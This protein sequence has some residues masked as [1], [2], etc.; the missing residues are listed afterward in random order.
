NYKCA[1]LES[2]IG[3]IGNNRK[4]DLIIAIELVEH[5]SNPEKFI[6]NCFS[7]LKPNGRVLI[8]TPNK[9]YYRKG[10]IWISDLP[11]VH[12]F[13][14][15]PKTFNYIAEENGL[16][17]KYFDLA[18]HILKHDKINLLINYLRSR[19]KIRIRPHVF[20]ASGELNLENHNSLNQP[21]LLKKLVRFILVDI[22][23]IRI[24]SN[25]LYRKIINPKFPNTSTQALLLWRG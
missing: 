24:L 2:F 22:A 6:K 9:G 5:L 3:S 19:E 1:D 17:L 20:K 14:L 21:S 23:P 13:W 4:F 12:L 11:P 25:F 15:S 7:I 10:S 16:N 18:S 8:T